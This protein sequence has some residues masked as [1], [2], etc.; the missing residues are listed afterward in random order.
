MKGLGHAFF[1]VFKSV[2]VEHVHFPWHDLVIFQCINVER[3]LV[4][5]EYLIEA[6]LKHYWEKVVQWAFYDNVLVLFFIFL[7]LI[8]IFSF[9]S[10]F[11]VITLKV[12]SKLSYE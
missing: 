4:G 9:S 3:M 10:I 6:L 7:F 2:V 1:F 12:F 8:T 11:L 5:F